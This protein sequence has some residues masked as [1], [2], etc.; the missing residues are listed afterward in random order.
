MIWWMMITFSLFLH[1]LY[2]EL[3]HSVGKLALSKH[4]CVLR[5]EVCVRNNVLVD[6][7]HISP[8]FSTSCTVNWCTQRV[9]CL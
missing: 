8:S 1:F 7:D 3:V 9:S 4:V 2:C 5:I 6:D